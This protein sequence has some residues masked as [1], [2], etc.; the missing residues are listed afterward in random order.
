MRLATLGM[1]HGGLG[2]G[3]GLGLSA[4]L[5]RCGAVMPWCV[6]LVEV[7]GGDDR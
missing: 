5:A 2:S 4:S 1:R 3:R 7:A 6:S